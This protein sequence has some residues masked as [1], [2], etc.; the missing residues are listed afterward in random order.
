M[1]GGWSA[2]TA[3][4]GA[5]GVASPVTAHREYSVLPISTS[6]TLA[7]RISGMKAPSGTA[8]F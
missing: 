1:R 7:D 6:D 5:M 3:A 8:L 2:C 4:R